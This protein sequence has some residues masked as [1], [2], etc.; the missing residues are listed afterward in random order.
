MLTDFGKLRSFFIEN[1]KEI[2]LRDLL[3]E[4]EI[5]MKGKNENY[6]FIVEK[7]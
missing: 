1:H 4:N 7:I 6:V 5:Y 2:H 3:H